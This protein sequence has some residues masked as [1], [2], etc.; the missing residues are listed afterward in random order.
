[1]RKITVALAAL[2]FK[3][4]LLFGQSEKPAY[5]KQKLTLQEA[6]IVS[7]YYQQNGNNSAVTGGQGTEQLTDLSNQLTIRLN[8][9]NKKGRSH[10]IT[11]VQ[12]I[13]VYTSASSDNIDRINSSPSRLD[14]RTYPWLGWET[15]NAEETSGISANASFSVEYDYNSYGFGGG[16]WT[17]SKDKNRL[18]SV[19]GQVFL[20]AWDVILPEE[21]RPEG[22]GSGG[23]NDP[24]P[25]DRRAR[26]SY[27][28]SL[29]YNQV[30]HPR[31]QVGLLVNPGFQQGLLSTPFHRVFD[32]DQQVKTE[33]LPDQR[34]KVPLGVQ[35]R[36]F[37]GNHFILRLNYRYY[38][39]T[40]AVNSHTIHAEVPI[41]IIPQLSISP[42][43]RW[44][45]QSAARYYQPF[46]QHDPMAALRTSDIDLAELSSIYTGLNIRYQSL[47]GF[48][49]IKNWNSIA[50]RAG[51]YAQSRGLNAQSFTLTTGFKLQE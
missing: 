16:W 25:I 5:T 51:F 15:T 1:M 23:E 12:G 7:S 43:L 47:K 17:Q 26:N 29:L 30:I 19:E 8:L 42:F 39:D 50:F 44:H 32:Q 9:R 20:D 14:V 34:F 45:Y 13:D 21:L 3:T 41:K 33:A 37:L 18:F 38:F 22:Y 28:L 31:L 4:L 35:L 36:Y 2:L 24:L 11:F 46:A 40:W 10:A 6:S 49:G 27:N 48:F